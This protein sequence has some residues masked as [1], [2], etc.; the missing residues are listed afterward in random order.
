MASRTCLRNFAVRAVIW[1]V[2]SGRFH[3]RVRSS[4]EVRV[5]ARYE[6]VLPQPFFLLQDGDYVPWRYDGGGYAGAVIAPAGHCMATS[7]QGPD[8]FENE[9]PRKPLSL[10]GFSG[11]DAGSRTPDLLI[12]SE[13]LCL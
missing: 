2:L 6:I 9:K 12:T 4:V 13:L 7:W 8:C 1:E 5:I 3:M 11:A 10:R